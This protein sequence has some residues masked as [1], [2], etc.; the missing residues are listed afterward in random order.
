[1]ADHRRAVDTDLLDKALRISES[2][3][4]RMYPSSAIPYLQ[5]AAPLLALPF[6]LAA[7]YEW[8]RRSPVTPKPWVAG[9]HWVVTVACLALLL[10]GLPDFSA[11]AARRVPD[12]LEVAE[13]MQ[14]LSRL[15]TAG[16]Y[17]LVT[18]QALLAGA[19]MASFRRGRSRA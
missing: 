17:L 12:F 7:V 14:L 5:F 1:V 13:R 2:S 18:A 11:P 8:L 15:A 9:C 10:F 4:D 19:A 6:L 3:V 16:F